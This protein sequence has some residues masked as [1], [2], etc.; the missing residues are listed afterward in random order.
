VTSTGIRIF[1]FVDRMINVRENSIADFGLG[2]HVVPLLPR[3]PGQ[4][5]RTR[6]YRVAE[7]VLVLPTRPPI[8]VEGPLSSKVV[9]VD[10]R[11]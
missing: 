7:N 8:K 1:G 11:P 5:N 9:V 10:N 2:I 3:G 4:I 6:L